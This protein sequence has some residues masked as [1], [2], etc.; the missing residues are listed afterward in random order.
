MKRLSIVLL[1]LASTTAVFAQS[2]CFRVKVVGKGKP[3]ILIPGLTCTGDVW[4][5]TVAQLKSKYECHVLTLPGFGNQPA[6]KAPYLSHVRDDIVAYVKNKKLNHP[7]V[8]GHSL[9]GF[10]V[11]Y[12]GEAAPKLFGP[13]IAVDGLP[14]LSL[15]QNKSATETNMLPIGEM[16][17]KQIAATPADKFKASTKSTLAAEITDPKN[18]ERV[19]PFCVQADQATVALVVKEMLTTDLRAGGS[20]IQ[21]PVLL[22][23]AGQQATT[24]AAKKGLT[25]DYEAQVK[26]IP[27]VKVVMDWKARHFIMVDDPAPFYQEVLDFL[28]HSWK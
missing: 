25:D 3:I 6:I 4:D 13:L 17:E 22:I 15:L 9:G 20:K 10:M 11:Y 14:F 28:H 16:V 24:D 23:G 7:A 8:I 2:Y 26:T 19:L 21:S 27:N 12:L 18:V 1:L 5:G